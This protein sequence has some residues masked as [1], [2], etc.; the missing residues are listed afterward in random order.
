M[1]N[2]KRI[3]KKVF[4][5]KKRANKHNGGGDMT[6]EDRRVMLETLSEVKELKGEM[7]EFKSHVIS[8]FENLEKNEGEGKKNRISVVA[9][10][11]SIM[12]FIAMIIINLF[13]GAK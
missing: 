1:K 3:E 5:R 2:E 7:R 12:S 6:V 10:F 8:R 11:I 9:I 13:K 4:G